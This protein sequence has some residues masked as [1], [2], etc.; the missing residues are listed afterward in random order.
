MV[1]YRSLIGRQWDYGTHDCFSLLRDYYELL[2]VSIP[3]FARPESLERADNLFV[4]YARRVGFQP[5]PFDERQ[6]HDV[7]IMRL[8]TE[9][10]MHAAIFVGG[11]RI[12]HQRMGSISAVEPLRR[13]YWRRTAAVFRHA[14]CLAGR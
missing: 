12:L 11:D 2:G 9:T 10:P 14:T 5:V 8:G 7:L 6:L 3:D 1:D 13:Y 4:R